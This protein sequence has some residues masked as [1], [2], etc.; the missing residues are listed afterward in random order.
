[1]SA[2]ERAREAFP[3]GCTT[4]CPDGPYDAMCEFC[5]CVRFARAEVRLAL[6]EAAQIA[7][8]GMNLDGSSSVKRISSVC[9]SIAACIRA[10]ARR[11]EENTEAPE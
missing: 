8:R 2:E 3:E 10:L 5:C 7:H 4:A 9:A 11:Y 1:M 6:E